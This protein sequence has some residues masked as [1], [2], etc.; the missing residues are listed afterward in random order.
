MMKRLALLLVAVFG[1]ICGAEGQ[2]PTVA[3]I[4]R[5]KCATCHREG[6]AAPFSITTHKDL[7]KRREMVRLVVERGIMP[8]WR[9]D[10][11]GLRFKHSR[12][13]S[14]AERSTLLAW[15]NDP[16]ETFG[17]KELARP[18]RFGEAPTGSITLA[19][20]E[21]MH[22]PPSATDTTIS[23][24]I[25]FEREKP[26]NIVSL[27]FRTTDWR[28]IHHVN[29]FVCDSALLPAGKGDPMK[30]VF[31]HGWA[32]G[33]AQFSFTDGVGFVLPKK[34]VIMGDVHFSATPELLQPRISFIL[35]TSPLPV[36]RPIRPI[37]FHDSPLVFRSGDSVRIAPG[38]VRHLQA[39]YV[40]NGDFSLVSLSP[41]MHIF[42]R[43]FRAYMVDGADTTQL[44]NIPDWD[45]AWQDFYLPERPIHLRKGAQ[46]FIEGKFDNTA[47]NPRQP[48][49][50]PVPIGNGWKITDE[51]FVM[52]MFGTPYRPGDE[53]MVFVR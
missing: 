5:D 37:V 19:L 15:L 21:R 33:N 28:G 14:A 26:E 9:A 24:S 32:P 52:F 1:S 16:T 8:P 13:L 39:H 22:V 25:P 51:M 42:G 6:T 48:F 27:E 2:Q 31:V 12:A 46:I 3:A 49:N 38:E 45:P 7:V 34:G 35:G 23:F 40:V 50:P 41:H 4:V 29:I 17:P 36:H 43:S 44:I 53:H 10:T 30:S 18:R 11:I 47:A 20:D